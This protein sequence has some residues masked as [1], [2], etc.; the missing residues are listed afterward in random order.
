MS[1]CTM[2]LSSAKVHNGFSPNLVPRAFPFFVFDT[3]KEKAWE[4]GMKCFET[5]FPIVAHLNFL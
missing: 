1:Q 5:C 3:N 2:P 4:R